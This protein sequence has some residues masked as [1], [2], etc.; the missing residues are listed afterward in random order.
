MRAARGAG[1]RA[2]PA[3]GPPWDRILTWALGLNL[4]AN[5]MSLNCC[6]VRLDASCCQ[7]G[8]RLPGR[9]HPCLVWVVWLSRGLSMREVRNH[10]PPP[11][12]WR[13]PLRHPNSESWVTLPLCHH[14]HCD[15]FFFREKMRKK[16]HQSRSKTRRA[17]S[18]RGKA[19]TGLPHYV[20]CGRG[21]AIGP[22]ATPAFQKRLG[23]RASRT[24]G[25]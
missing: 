9:N 4:E 11:I 3:P 10:G 16:A 18:R 14:V 7:P 21:G 25:K 1:H 20:G 6:S 24:A 15:V 2:M 5:N 23:E 8:L 19:K 13:L 17:T 22:N 12:A